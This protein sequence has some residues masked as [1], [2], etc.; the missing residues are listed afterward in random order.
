MCF[1]VNV[2]LA[3]EASLPG[4]LCFGSAVQHLG[5]YPKESHRY[6]FASQNTYPL[7][8]IEREGDLRIGTS[9]LK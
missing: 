1:N 3:M 2:L 8:E 6:F 4:Q 9:G 5:Y 7:R